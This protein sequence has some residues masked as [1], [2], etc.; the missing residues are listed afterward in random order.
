MNPRTPRLN[1]VLF[2]ALLAAGCATQ[3]GQG[4]SAGDDDGDAICHPYAAH[5]LCS[6]ERKF[7]SSLSR[8][9]T[10][11]FPPKSLPLAVMSVWIDD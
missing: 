5:F 8:P 10:I 7:S 9:T 1:P 4:A 3:A 6:G 11:T 2:F